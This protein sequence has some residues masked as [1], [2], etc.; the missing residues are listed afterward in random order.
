M[1]VGQ[2]TRKWVVNDSRIREILD[3]DT[4]EFEDDSGK[5]VRFKPETDE[6]GIDGDSDDPI[7]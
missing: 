2:N 5:R 7:Q 6:D 3:K 1:G 4:T